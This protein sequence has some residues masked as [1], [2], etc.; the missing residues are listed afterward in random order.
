[1]KLFRTLPIFLVLLAATLGLAVP[2]GE[3]AVAD[4]AAHPLTGSNASFVQGVEGR[5]VAPFI[6]LGAKHMVTGLDHV[7]FLVGV[8]FFLYRPKDVVLYVSLFTAGHSLTLLAGVIGGVS[9]NPYVIDAIIGFSV[10][11]KA[12]ENMGGFER[13]FGVHPNT[14]IAVFAFGLVHGLGLATRLQDFKLAGDGLIANILSFNVGVEIGQVLALTAV[15]LVLTSW[16]MSSSF[17][18]H[19]FLTNTAL[20]TAGFVL[21]G[22]QAIGF[23]LS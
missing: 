3:W 10:V 4:L 5:A 9:V 21:A 6:Y 2:F 15:L 14:R 19:A 8:V 22:Q 17:R 13:L 12:F 16:R 20:M 7:L 18:R 1:M 11:Y 23:L